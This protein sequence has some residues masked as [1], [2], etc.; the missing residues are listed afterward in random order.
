MKMRL[1]NNMAG[2]VQEVVNLTP[3]KITNMSIEEIARHAD[4]MRKKNRIFYKHLPE[5]N[6]ILYWQILRFFPF[7]TT[8][9]LYY[10]AKRFAVWLCADCYTKEL[11]INNALIW[12][13]EYNIKI[14]YHF[15]AGF[16]M[17]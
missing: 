15:R 13:Y 11:S 2:I 8:Y 1:T 17:E 12:V 10:T 6:N 5:N 3:E 14:S 16:L 4:V 9:I 7:C